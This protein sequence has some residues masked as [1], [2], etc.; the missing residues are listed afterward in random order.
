MKPKIKTDALGVWEVIGFEQRDAKGDITYPLG[1]AIV[2][3]LIYTAAGI[4]AVSV[5]SAT[6]PGASAVSRLTD[7]EA[8]PQM[9]LGGTFQT[10]G[11]R[12]IHDASVCSNFEWT[13][14]LVEFLVDLDGER[15]TCHII[16]VAGAAIP[17]PPKIVAVR[18]PTSTTLES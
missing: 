3:N 5:K 13:G 17:Y 11:D 4:F 7:E 6:R 1:T 9:F 15:L 18:K 2:G 8:P 16:K 12:I 14:K 10:S